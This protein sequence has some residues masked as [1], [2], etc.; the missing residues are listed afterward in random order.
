MSVNLD[1]NKVG[2][3]L[4]K[5]SA[6]AKRKNEKRKTQERENKTLTNKIIMNEREK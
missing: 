6:F 2:L 4:K 3:C 1:V 5:I